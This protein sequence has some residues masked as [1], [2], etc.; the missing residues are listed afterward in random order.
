MQWPPQRTFKLLQNNQIT[1]SGASVNAHQLKWVNQLPS[2]HDIR[3]LNRLL[4]CLKP[5]RLAV[6]YTLLSA[7]VRA[8]CTSCALW[9]KN[10]GVALP[11]ML[12]R[13]EKVRFYAAERWAII[14]LIHLVWRS[15]TLLYVNLTEIGLWL[16]PVIG[17]LG[18][19]VN[20]W[21]SPWLLTTFLSECLNAWCW[22]AACFFFRPLFYLS[23][24]L[25]FPVS[26]IIRPFFCLPAYLC[27]C[28]PACLFTCQTVHLSFIISVYA[29]LRSLTPLNAVS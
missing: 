9:S 26:L 11:W 24:W 20:K 1:Y 6:V 23:A 16:S 18:V 5:L 29:L 27:V 7:T 28:L 13:K 21:F 17:V 12:Q 2:T 19:H 25:N 14:A 15:I 8:E 22:E 10:F 3:L 4:P